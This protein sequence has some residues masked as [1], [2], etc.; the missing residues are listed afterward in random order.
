MLFSFRE[1]FNLPMQQTL[2]TTEVFTP[3]TPAYYAYVEREYLNQ[4][5]VDALRTPG[6]QIIVF[7][8]TGSGKTTLLHNKLNQTYEGKIRC[9]C[10]QQ[11]TFDQILLDAFDQLE[12]FYISETSN[13]K[14]RKLSTKLERDFM[15]IKAEVGAEIGNSTETKV[16]RTL[17]PQLT[18]SRLARFIGEIKHCWVIEDV[19]KINQEEKIKISQVMKVFMDE[20]V[21]YPELKIILAGAV[22]TAKEIITLEKDMRNRTIEIFVPL[23]SEHEL[24]AII[25]KGENKL[26]LSLEY[27][28]TEAISKF[29]C[30]LPSVTHQ[31]C[32]NICL[33]K[34]IYETC[35]F[36]TEL[37]LSDFIS[38]LKKY[39]S[40]ISD[41]L[42]EH[43]D[44]AIRYNEASK[45]LLE[46]LRSILLA[47]K[48]SVTKKEIQNKLN[49]SSV[50]FSI[51][52]L[53][54]SLNY[55]SSTSSEEV[56]NYDPLTQEYSFLNPFFKVYCY[57]HIELE[58]AEKNEQLLF[59]F[60]KENDKNREMIRLIL[61]D[62]GYS[63]IE[64]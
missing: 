33:N 58:K 26:N 11:T 49:L 59:N 50:H 46:V 1:N 64:F 41:S 62:G 47:N 4:Q 55:L 36:H 6:K 19:H 28:L 63:D 35:E 60:Q 2:S 30:G 43:F 5:L 15:F 48:Y 39:V 18:P 53:T 40:E 32:L 22:G 29:S 24:K 9:S 8:Q 38:A 3:S 14:S 17:P 13:S 61:K 31:L 27:S 51:E 12:T 45:F 52:Q 57:C 56:L 34:Q 23:M 16:S 10:T 25:S 42:K 20:A 21:N 44:R 7:G 37:S 54:H